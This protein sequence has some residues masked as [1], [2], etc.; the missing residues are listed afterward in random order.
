MLFVTCKDRSLLAGNNC[1]KTNLRGQKYESNAFSV[2]YFSSNASGQVR[3]LHYRTKVLE[4]PLLTS[5]QMFM[6]CV[7]CHNPDFCLK[8]A[9]TRRE[10]RFFVYHKGNWSS[11]ESVKVVKPN[12]D[13][14]KRWKYCQTFYRLPELKN[15]LVVRQVR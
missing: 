1:Y 12:S 13:L 4:T 6:T 11:Q 8:L 7:I 3:L 2:F 5:C 15:F 9:K 14:S 10:N